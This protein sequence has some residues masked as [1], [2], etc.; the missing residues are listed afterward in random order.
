[1]NRRRRTL[2]AIGVIVGLAAWLA[3]KVLVTQHKVPAPASAVQGRGQTTGTDLRCD[4][5]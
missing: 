4:S 1:M 2:L 3:W 5:G